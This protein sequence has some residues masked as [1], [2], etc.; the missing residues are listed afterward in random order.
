MIVNGDTI[1][2]VFVGMLLHALLYGAAVG[3]IL[4]IVLKLVGADRE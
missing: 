2:L 3:L 1:A 4:A